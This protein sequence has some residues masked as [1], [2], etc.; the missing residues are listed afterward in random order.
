MHMQT[1]KRFLALV[2]AA[3]MVLAPCTAF[4]TDSVTS[5]AIGGES[6]DGKVEGWVDKEVFTVVL[7]TVADGALDFILDPQGLIKDTTAGSGENEGAYNG[8]KFGEGTL[9][10]NHATQ[11]DGKDYTNTSD[12]LTIVNKSSIP[13]DVKVDVIATGDAVAFTTDAAFE[14]ST[15]AEVYLA[16]K[17]LASTGD[18]IYID[19]ETETATLT[20][21]LKKVDEKFFEV[22]YEG[23]KYTYKLKT[24]GGPASSDLDK[25]EFALTGAANPNGD[26]SS[27]TEIKPGVDVV[28]TVTGVSSKAL[29]MPAEPG[30]GEKAYTFEYGKD[31]Q[32]AINTDGEEIERLGFKVGLN[33]GSGSVTYF[34][35]VGTDYIVSGHVLTLPG[36]VGRIANATNRSSALD[37]SLYVRVASGKVYI[38]NLT[39]QPR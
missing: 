6:G 22:K 13:V 26:W 7:P 32:M 3:A 19:P 37:I 27:K 17:D 36:T 23:G 28:W 2:A 1:R 24:T 21:Q 9:F 15:K 38:T 35:E 14:E 12:T 4:A 20:A 16:I 33:G 39:I 10:F 29:P 8:K 18:A 34:D 25:I 30:F 31:L 5:P 11:V